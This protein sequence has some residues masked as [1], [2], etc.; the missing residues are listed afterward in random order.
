MFTMNLTINGKDYEL[1]FGLDFIS[2]LDKE[3]YIEQD[4]FKIGH[5]LT[6][7]ITQIE[8]GNPVVLVDLILAAT[9]T[10]N[11]PK[12]D[13]VKKF[14]ENEVDIEVLM[15]DF[16]S[17]LETTPITRFNL[18]KMGLLIEPKK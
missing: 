15:N 11:R 18:K 17:A 1:Y 4:G 5:G 2:Y 14:I 6:T 10:G 7:V 9:I 16:L 12:A 13:E 8:M 3:H